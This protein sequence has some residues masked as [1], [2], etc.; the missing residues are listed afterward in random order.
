MRFKNGAA[1]LKLFADYEENRLTCEGCSFEGIASEGRD[2]YEE[3]E[4]M[5]KFIDSLIKM[6]KKSKK[7][8]SD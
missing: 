1:L 8:K 4:L 3:V 2:C 7:A 6:C 5:A